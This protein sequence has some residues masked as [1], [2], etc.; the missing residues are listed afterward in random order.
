MG[1]IRVGIDGYWIG[2]LRYYFLS[3]C[4]AKNIRPDVEDYRVKVILAENPRVLSCEYLYAERYAS[5]CFY[6][7]EKSKWLKK[8]GGFATLDDCLTDKEVNSSALRKDLYRTNAF[9][10][11]ETKPAILPESHL[12]A[13]VLEELRQEKEFY[14]KKL[15][16]IEIK[17][18]T[19]DG[20]EN[21]W[22]RK[23]VNG[24]KQ[25]W[26]RISGD[27]PF[28]AVPKQ[29]KTETETVTFNGEDHIWTRTIVIGGAEGEWEQTAGSNKFSTPE[30]AEE[31]FQKLI[32]QGKF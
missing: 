16:V 14:N 25:D 18:I 2:D 21:K 10:F 15:T 6:E 29:T 4:I 17:T 11:N 9:Y 1:D 22:Q 24:V 23:I 31:H 19:V 28:D 13:K 7:Y 3:R 30:E 5:S 12:D 20:R 26:T 32:E 8:F 27:D